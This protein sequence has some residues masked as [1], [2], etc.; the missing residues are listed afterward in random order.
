MCPTAGW[1]TSD[2][3]GLQAVDALVSLHR[4]ASKNIRAAVEHTTSMGRGECSVARHALLNASLEV[5]GSLSAS[6]PPDVDADLHH[7]P[8]HHAAFC[9]LPALCWH[10]L[11]TFSSY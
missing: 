10:P 4:Q 9:T 1:L 11:S 8:L 5:L 2:H 7:L 6:Y 3:A